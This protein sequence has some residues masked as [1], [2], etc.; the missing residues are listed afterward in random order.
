MSQQT[1]YQ[2]GQILH[3]G[4]CFTE[5]YCIRGLNVKQIGVEL[6]LPQHRLN[7]GVFIAFARKLPYFH[8]FEL[9]GWAKFSTDK[10]VEYRKGKMN[11]ILSDFE[12]TYAGKRMPISIE[13][14]K[15]AWLKNMR[16]EKLIK[17]LP[18]IPHHDDDKY[19]AGGL[20][21]QIIVRNKIECEIVQFLKSN[22]VFKDVWG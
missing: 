3:L 18:V 14:A 12:K 13:D 1:P 22:E 2:V 7:D 21:S 10:F 17:V 5:E 6:G 8:D 9:G 11:W 15:N 19:P 16:H 20:A 4:G